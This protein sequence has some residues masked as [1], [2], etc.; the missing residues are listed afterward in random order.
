MNVG[1]IW[2]DRWVIVAV[3]MFVGESYGGFWFL[4]RGHGD[5][6]AFGVVSRI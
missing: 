1:E 6:F 3:R 5:G 4:Q 2:W